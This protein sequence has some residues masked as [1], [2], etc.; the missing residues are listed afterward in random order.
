MGIFFLQSY[1]DEYGHIFIVLATINQLSS[2]WNKRML[3]LAMKIVSEVNNAAF[4][5][6]FDN[7]TSVV[8]DRIFFLQVIFQNLLPILKYNGF[9]KF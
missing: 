8:P 1:P 2:S 5:V 3:R 9:L 4:Q 7:G 6:F